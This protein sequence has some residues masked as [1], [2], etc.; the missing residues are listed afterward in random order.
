MAWTPDQLRAIEES[1]TNIIVS[2]GAGSGKTA[3]LT[4]RVLEKLKHGIHINELLILTFTNA[5]A[6]EMK[7]RIKKNIEKE[8][9]EEELELIDASYITT[10]DSFALSLV[11]KYHYLL[12]IP[13]NITITDASIISL[14]KKKILADI[15]ERFYKEKTKDFCDLI[16][17]L[18]VKDDEDL[19]KSILSLADKL[20]MKTDLEDYLKNYLSTYY[21]EKTENLIIQNY[22]KILENKIEEIFIELEDNKNYFDTDYELK[23]REALSP[24]KQPVTLDE[25][26]AII[27]ASKLPIAPRGSEEETK[28][29]KEKVNAKLKDCKSYCVYGNETE[30]LEDYNKTKPLIHAI[31][32][33]LT[34]YFQALEKYKQ[35]NNIFDFTDIAKLSLKLMK[36][37]ISIKNELKETFKE[38]M[39][40][41]YQDTSDIQEEFISLISN[42]NVY[43]VGDIKQ[44]IYRFRN[45][46][47]YIFKEKYDK[48]KNGLDGIKIDLL[49]NFRSRSEVL[50]NIN[51]IFN[52]VM[53]DE[54]GNADYTSSHQM[55]FGNNNYI[56][57]GKTAHD[58]N[59]II[60]TYSTDS[61]EYSKE[62]IE[63]F[64]IAKDISEKITM[65][66][67]VLD[68]NTT[69]LRPVTYKDFCI[70]MD[71]NSTFDLTKKI[72]EFLGIPLSLYKDEEL[73][74]GYDIYIIKNLLNLVIH[75][76]ERNYHQ[77]F[78]Y[79]LVSIARSFLYQIPDEEI[80]TM[81]KE[82]IELQSKIVKDLYPISQKLNT[83][84]PKE[85]LM[86][87]IEKTNYYEKLITTGNIKE[88]ILKIEKIMELANSNNL[89]IY[90]FKDYLEELL[91][92]NEL[93]K[94][95]VE[96]SSSNSVKIM[97][98]HKSKGLEFPICY[99]AG[100][101][102]SFSKQDLKGDIIYMPNMPIYIPIWKEGVYET[103]L[104]LLMKDKMTKEDISEKIRLFY[105]ALT[106]AKEKM[107]L[108][109]PKK[110]LPEER[111]N[112]DGVI[113]KTIRYKY[114]SLASIL[115][116]IP[117][118]LKIYG[119][120]LD[121]NLL[122]L[123]KD[124]ML[125]KEK[126]STKENITPLQ[127][128]ELNIM[129]VETKK[130]TFSK[131]MNK[132]IDLSTKRNIDFGISIHE[133]LEH[134]NFKNPNLEPI[135]NQFIKNI[136]EKLLATPLLKNKENAEIYQEYEFIEE[137]DGMEYHGKIDLMLV[138][139]DHIDIIDY[140][141]NNVTDDAY[142]NQ[143]NGYKSYIERHTEKK[144]NIYLFSL[145]SGT[146]T[147]L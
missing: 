146:I 83:A 140:K 84:S 77:E 112:S 128:T 137:K 57:E 138:Y 40:D 56:E 55:V 72:F 41:E 30:I 141:L 35:E 15:L 2:A 135:K 132:L 117:S 63:I 23:I 74:N 116:S 142:I 16:D 96:S 129:N 18:C 24:L 136:I 51:I 58:N 32:E 81:I 90:Q 122:G 12:N 17:T 19:Q 44:S 60:Y 130:Q 118:V 3:V 126:E 20:N 62:E 95:N 114:S 100:L 11:R 105:V 119:Q 39:V 124:Y 1:G 99:F 7:E 8:N 127:I 31:L 54:I 42:Q 98:I 4:T 46:N 93:I 13:K 125:P 68:K 104:K 29:A 43:M 48:Y 71:R 133:T 66:Y 110:E 67:P 10:F 49:K 101:Y 36:E 52:K 139:N 76:K 103:V 38:I 109:L 25:K 34:N 147:E 79:S 111:K 6:A 120:D 33:I 37:N 131:K 82:N 134:I 86:D 94:F 26:I 53:D 91:T 27:K 88:S 5:A 145:L 78:R 59:M 70:I 75:L 21:N 107:I 92:K 45:A 50:E 106:R 61:K 123:T 113:L 28:E 121:L 144:V 97:N 65:K 80:L 85:I 47:P 64:A 143:L 108:F 9:L 73:N 69:T 22:T 14:Q 87:I 115:Y 102:K 89:D